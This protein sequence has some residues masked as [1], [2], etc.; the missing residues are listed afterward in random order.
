MVKSSDLFKGIKLRA[1]RHTV[2]NWPNK[3]IDIVDGYKEH[4][5]V[6]HGVQ[7]D[8]IQNG[9]D[10]RINK[11]YG[12]GWS[13]VFELVKGK[14]G[15]TFL[16]MTDKGTTGL[17]GRVLQSEELQEDLP[18]EERWG[19][20]E[21]VAFTKGPSEEALGSRGKGKFIFVGASKNYTILYDT[22]RE[23][24]IYRFGYRT[25]KLTDSPIDAFDNN[26]GKKLLT[27]LTE[28]VLT[29]LSEIGTRVII[30]DPIDEVI[31]SIESGNFLRFIGETWWEI[32]SKFSKYGVQILVKQNGS[33]ERATIPN[34]F[35][36][37]EMDNDTYKVW[38]K[39]EIKIKYMGVK[40]VIKRLHIVRNTTFPVPDDIRGVAIQRGGM[41]ICPIYIRYVPQEIADSVYGYITFD[42]KLDKALLVDEGSEHYSYNFGRGLPRKIKLLIEDELATFAREKLGCGADP[43][44]VEHERQANAEHRAVYAM[45]R[46]IKK[47]GLFGGRGGGGGGGGNGG[48]EKRKIRI[49]MESMQFPRES[50]RINWGESLKNIIVWAAND[51]DKSV[52]VRLKMYL[53]H[54]E[55][56]V[57]HLLKN[58]DFTLKPYGRSKKFGPFHINFNKNDFPGRGL[59]I[60]RAKLLLKST[61]D[62]KKKGYELHILSRRFYLEEDPPERG[63]FERCDGMIFPEEQNLIMGEA[64]SGESGGYIFQYNLDHPAKKSSD[65][66]EDHL[67]DYLFR[68]M[69]NEV[70]RIDIRSDMRKIFSDEDLKDPSRLSQEISRLIGKIMYEYYMG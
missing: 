60:I 49:E 27:K 31:R 21:N 57:Y 48:G 45:N 42:K 64:I 40:Y 61:M 7:K 18:P 38:F 29:P 3:V 69:A 34:E 26:E 12:K 53:L 1:P 35:A 46:V 65:E 51:T 6:S 32:I 9:W 4:R 28:G 70:P 5:G 2:I 58:K 67:T 44:K 52:P 17:T 59:Y 66:T 11:R 50:R 39:K 33:K 24:G 37:P 25:V 30:V 55:H 16:T 56:E 14:Y 43:R 36:L 54:H 20:F 68:I 8:A 19:R 15:R 62:D 63:L 13:L 47:L 23:D 41:K 10:A 22:L